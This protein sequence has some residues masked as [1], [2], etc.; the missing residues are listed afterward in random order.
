MKE[1]KNTVYCTYQEAPE[2]HFRGHPEAPTRIQAMQSWLEEPPYPEVQWLEFEPAKEGDITLVHDQS[3]LLFLQ[4]ECQAGSH[5]FEPSPSYVT[6]YSYDAAMG[7][8]GAV[9]RVS[10]EIISN[11]FGRGFAIVRPPGH[12]ADPETSMGFCLLNN[13]AI[14]A[15]DAVASGLSRVAIVDFDAHHGNGTQTVFWDTPEVGYLS[16]HE[17]HIFPGTGRLDEAQHAKGRII[18]VPLPPFSGNSAFDQISKK[19]LRPWLSSFQPEMLFV[20]AGFDGHFSDPLTTL[21]LDTA[22]YYQL[23]LNLVKIA[24]EFC[25]ERI[26]FVL[27][28]GYDPLA[29]KDNIQAC[30]AAMSGHETFP[31][32]YGKSPDVKPDVAALIQHLQAHHQ[33]QEN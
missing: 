11:E 15:A 33:L 18:N 9:L 17:G 7:A 16:T 24:D 29:L 20:S 28:G 4:E 26:M 31:D 27:E 5:E 25:H 30:L 22:G 12:H 1:Y 14:A 6:K 32:H 21:S 10:R 23:A 19:I 8:V 3:L 2:H 13:I